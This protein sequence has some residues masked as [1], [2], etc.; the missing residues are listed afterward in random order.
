MCKNNLESLIGIIVIGVGRFLESL[1][2]EDLERLLKG[3]ERE[4]HVNFSERCELLFPV[5]VDK[6]L[7]RNA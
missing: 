4:K 7:R 6:K 2:L 3:W 5:W 1:L